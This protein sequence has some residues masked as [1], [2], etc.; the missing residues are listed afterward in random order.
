VQ[1]CPKSNF[2]TLGYFSK[3]TEKISLP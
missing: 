2:L 1:I 3:K